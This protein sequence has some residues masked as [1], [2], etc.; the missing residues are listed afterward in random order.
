MGSVLRFFLELR[1]ANRK[2]LRT[3]GS[4]RTKGSGVYDDKGTPNDLT[5]D[6]LT[7]LTQIQ[8]IGLPDSGSS[9]TNDLVTTTHVDPLGM[10]VKQIDV[11]GNEATS[12]YN[13]AG[14][15][16]S[17]TD[18][19]GNTTQEGVG[20]IQSEF[21]GSA[22]ET[23]MAISAGG[24]ITWTPPASM[25]NTTQFVTVVATSGG[26][27]AAQRFALRVRPANNEPVVTAP[28]AKSF[29]AGLEYRHDVRVTDVDLD[30]IA[31]SLT[32]APAGM[33]IDQYG[34]IRWQ[35]SIADLT[36]AGAAKAYTFQV[37]ATDNRG[38]AETPVSVTLTVQP[39]SD[40]A[41]GRR[42]GHR[43]IVDSLA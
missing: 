3:K 30:P 21:T 11:R 34:R 29:A 43:F 15:V 13:K 12:I 17:Q 25:V 42:R 5:D 27:L 38:A 4:Q 16:T 31:Y 1:G 23:Q 41:G 37:L 36:A 22:G 19:Q 35:T 2:G 18:A 32:G 40:D 6:K 10:P 33:A 14:Q 26:L 28:P 7:V 24:V 9:E 20:A 8:V 39:D